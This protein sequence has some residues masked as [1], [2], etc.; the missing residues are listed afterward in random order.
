MPEHYELDTRVLDGILA[1]SD[2]QLEEWLDALAEDIVSDIKLSFGESPSQP[3][4]PP[5]VDTGALR[6][7]MHWEPDGRLRRVIMDGVEYGLYLE[8]GTTTLQ[9]RPFVQPVFHFWRS[10]VGKHAADFGLLSI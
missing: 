5:G 6:A 2:V 7:S 10:Q 4:E 9:P 3:G 8:E 1:N